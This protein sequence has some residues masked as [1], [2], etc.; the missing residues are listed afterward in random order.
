[1]LER[2]QKALTGEEAWIVGGAVRDELLA[3]FPREDRREIAI[4]TALIAA[5]LTA[6]CYL[7]I[8]APGADGVGALSAS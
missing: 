7:I 1:M 5:S 4:D 2:A 8:R 6:I 3:L